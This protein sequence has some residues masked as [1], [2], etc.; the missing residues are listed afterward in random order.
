MAPVDP[1][2]RDRLVKRWVERACTDARQAGERPIT[3]SKLRVTEQ[4]ELIREAQYWHRLASGELRTEAV[5]P[6]PSASNAAAM[7]DH[8]AGCRERL[9]SMMS[10]RGDLLPEGTGEEFNTIMNR[11]DDALAVVDEC[12]PNGE[13]GWSREADS[14][15]RELMGWAIKLDFARRHAPY[16]AADPWEPDG[17]TAYIYGR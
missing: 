9:Q 7:R 10:A 4:R 1:D 11:I 5:Q 17:W 13:A 14:A 12:M 3:Y 6:R 2:A 16:E 8:L 15:W